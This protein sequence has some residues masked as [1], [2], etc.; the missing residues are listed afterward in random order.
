MP[1]MESTNTPKALSISAVGVPFSAERT[2]SNSCRVLSCGTNTVTKA[3]ATIINSTTETCGMYPPKKLN[4]RIAVA[5][6]LSCFLQ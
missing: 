2:L 4:R 1:K 5:A 3:S 6:F